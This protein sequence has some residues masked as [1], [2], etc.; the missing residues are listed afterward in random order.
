MK[1]NICR[2]VP[3]T[4]RVQAPGLTKK[5]V[6]QEFDVIIYNN[7][8]EPPSLNWRPLPRRRLRQALRILYSTYHTIKVWKI[9]TFSLEV[10]LASYMKIETKFIKKYPL[11]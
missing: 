6:N 11:K 8:R 2:W 9:K 7:R 3:T 5:C 4:S 10:Q 1:A